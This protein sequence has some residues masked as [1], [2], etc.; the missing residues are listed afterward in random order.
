MTGQDWKKVEDALSSPYGQ[1]KL[2]VDGYE[3][4]LEVD[5]LKGLQFAIWVWVDGWIK[6]E[7]A[8]ADSE[9]GRRFYRP[10][11]SYAFS[12]DMRKAL[13]AV[14]KK[15]RPADPGEKITSY[16]PHWLS[17]GPLKRHLLKNNQN[18]ELVEVW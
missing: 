17:F 15:H 14:P 5:R 6:T 12:A 18:I 9:I 4:R 16:M 11:Q 1:A 3:V 13:N 7:W 10:A 8:T 2:L